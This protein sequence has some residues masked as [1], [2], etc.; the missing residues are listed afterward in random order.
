MNSWSTTILII[1]D[2]HSQL[3][4]YATS[5]Q[6]VAQVICADNLQ[7]AGYYLDTLYDIRAIIFDGQ[8]PETPGGFG[9]GLTTLPL[10][11]ECRRRRPFSLRI[12]ASSDE[13][14]RRRM[15][16]AGCHQE[17]EKSKVPDLIRSLLK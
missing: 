2:D 13:R 6:F 9:H 10:I 11:Q 17:S 14:W 4:T 3:D 15:V 12:A 5:L 7:V 8:V 16:M 1:E